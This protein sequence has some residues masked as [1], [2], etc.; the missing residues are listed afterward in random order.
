M[1]NIIV[2]GVP[3]MCLWRFSSKYPTDHLLWYLENA[4]F[5]MEA[6]KQF[7]LQNRAVPLQLVPQI[8]CQKNKKH[9]VL[10]IVSIMLKSCVL[11]HI[12]LN[13]WYTIFWVHR[14]K[15][16]AQKAAVTRHV[17]TKLSSLSCSIVLKLSNTHKF[18]R[19][20]Q[21]QKRFHAFLELLPCR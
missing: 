9:L 21:W 10:N 17:S 4:Y 7:F 15:A 1:C 2:S 3:R 19:T 11:N 5:W 13:F 20:S 8:L 16:C 6:E 14:S 12:S 18:I